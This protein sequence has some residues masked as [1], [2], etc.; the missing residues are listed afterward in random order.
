MRAPYRIV[1]ADD[2]VLLRQGLRRILE[3]VGDLEVIGEAGN[4]LELLGL[5]KRLIPHLVVLDISMPHLRGI[6]A[7]HEVKVIHP[8]LKVLILT[9]HKEMDLL[10]AAISAGAHGYVLKED[11]DT[12]LFAAIEQIRQ[13]GTYVSPKLSDEVADTLPQTCRRDGRPPPE[14]EQLTIREKQVLKL[15]AEGRSSKEIAELLGI[16]SRT[17][18]NHRANIMAE[19]NLK[20]TAELVRY[21]ISRGYL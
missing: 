4:G 20:R 7:I 6:E 21:A 11:A 16:S 10:I 1:L 3:G 15:I 18:D 13:G 5:L 12:Q 14:G 17:V 9:M 19:L 8:H 2:H